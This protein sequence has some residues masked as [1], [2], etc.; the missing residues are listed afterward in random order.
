MSI[1][2]PTHLLRQRREKRGGIVTGAP[3]C[4]EG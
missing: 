1:A 3:S 2:R 4:N